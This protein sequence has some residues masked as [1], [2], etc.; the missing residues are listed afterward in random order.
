M[1]SLSDPPPSGEQY[2]LA[3]G[4]Q[5]ATVVEV[6]GGVRTYM[7][8]GRD[9]LHPYNRAAVCDG[10]HGTPLVPW[11]NRIADGRYSFD[12]ADQQL[13]LTEPDKHNAIH[14]LLRWQP[15]RLIQRT[16]P[17]VVLG[18]RLHPQPG[19]P[20]TLDVQVEYT[21]TGQGLTA[22]TTATNRGSTPCP[23]GHGQHP[24]LSPGDGLVDACLLQFS[25]GTRIV[26]DPVRQLPTGTEAVAGT[27]Y[28]FRAPRLIGEL[29]IDFA[30]TDL[31]R[32]D[33]GRAQV[34]LTGPD[35]A[36]ALLWVDGT[37]PVLELYTADTLGAARRRTALGTEPMTCPPNAFQTGE[38]VV[39]LEPGQS[40]TTSWG[41]RLE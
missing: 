13:D 30:F 31:V 22:T 2:V 7:V 21:L 18:T 5:S 9:V 35:G 29:A 3:W 14:G 25:A 34:R 1:S 27:Q 24:Y 39:R 41:A 8:D 23:Y 20:F 15:W 26:T 37:F 4:S 11:P 12:G 10:A 6:G 19:Y 40:H 38:R 28:D 33:D 36:T 17:R 32:D 16:P